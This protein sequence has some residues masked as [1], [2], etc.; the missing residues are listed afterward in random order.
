MRLIQIP[1]SGYVTE[2]AIT[3]IR[4]SLLVTF[5][6]SDKNFLGQELTILPC[7]T[8]HKYLHSARQIEAK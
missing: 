1:G 6:I 4:V 8:L 7:L 3:H 2:T 5:E